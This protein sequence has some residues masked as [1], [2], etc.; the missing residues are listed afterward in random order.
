VVNDGTATGN[1]NRSKSVCEFGKLD[2][3]RVIGS[4]VEEVKWQLGLSPQQ[5]W[6]ALASFAQ[7]I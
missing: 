5:E 1:A 3:L 7:T 6:Q 2:V 4:A